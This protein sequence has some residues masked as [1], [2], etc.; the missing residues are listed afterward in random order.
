MVLFKLTERSLGLISMLILVRLLSPA[1]FGT[2]AMAMSFIVMAELLAAFGFDVAL[3]QMQDTDE[4]HY[5]TAWTFNLLLGLL[6]TALMLAAAPAI[7]SFYKN[8]QVFWVVCALA[9]GPLIAGCENI[10]VVAFRK[11]MQ[12]RREF[13]FQL[14]RKVIGFM[15]VVPLAYYMRSYWALV[16]GILSAKLAGTVTSYLAHPFRPRFSLSRARGL[17]NFSK[18]LLMNNAVSFL[19]ERSSDFFIGRMLGAAPLGLYNISYEVALMPTTELAAPINRALLPG[20]AS[21]AK[22]PEAMRSA[23]TNAI[24][25][26]VLL[27]VPAAAGIF[28]VAP[29]FVPVLLGPKWLDSV[30]LMEILALNGGLLMFHSSICTVLIANGHPHRVTRTNSLFVVLLLALLGGLIPLFGLN[31]AAYAA[32]GASVLTT[33]LYLSE[34]HRSLGVPVMQFVRVGIRPLIAA[35]VMAGLVRWILPEWTIDTKLVISIGWL[36]GGVTVGVVSY[37]ATIL[38]LW[39]VAGRPDGAERILFERVRQR[40]TKTDVASSAKLS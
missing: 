11:E 22:D 31:G 12:F 3:I 21:I 26:L 25:M 18:W 13:I 27:A 9:L 5:H 17:M 1:D 16:A 14:S 4:H 8:P 38:L 36:F 30:P 7:A 32:L 15:V 19:K 28:A 6:I 24:G 10:G 35:M 37:S 40:M 29:F 2:V 20:F 23:Y 39:F 34:I 33:P